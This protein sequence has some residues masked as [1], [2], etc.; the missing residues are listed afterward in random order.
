MAY[1][2]KCRPQP[3]VNVNLSGSGGTGQ[4][5]IVG[6]STATPEVARNGGH[7]SAQSGHGFTKGLVDDAIITL[8]PPTQPHVVCFVSVWDYDSGD[9]TGYTTAHN[10]YSAYNVTVTWVGMPPVPGWSGDPG[11]ISQAEADTF[12][13]SVQTELGVTVGNRQ[14]RNVELLF[15]DVHPNVAGADMIHARL[16]ELPRRNGSRNRGLT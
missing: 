6:D 15:D 4:H 8:Y 13:D 10:F 11:G 9:L 16:I 1:P 12:N 5:Y 7:G 3:I 14:L 2:T